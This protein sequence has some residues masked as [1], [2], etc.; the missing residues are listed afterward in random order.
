[1][2]PRWSWTRTWIAVLGALITAVVIGVPTG[3]ISSPFY[4]RMTPAPWWSYV[5]WGATAILSGPL[6]ATYV[7]ATGRTPR[8]SGAGALANIGSV[9]AVGCP[10]CNKVVVAALGVSGALSVWAPLQPVIAVAALALLGWALWLR[11]RPETVCPIG[12]YPPTDVA[13]EA[14][15]PNYPAV[16]PLT[17]STVAEPSTGHERA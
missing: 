15:V 4:V 10:V 5:A 7:Q 6:I 9:L 14:V 17:T 3:L 8:T 11:V 1:M 13:L 2:T 12:A 16:A